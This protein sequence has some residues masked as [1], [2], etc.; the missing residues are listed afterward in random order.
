MYQKKYKLG[1]SDVDSSL[2][3]K[4]SSLFLMMQ[5]IAIEHAELLGIGKS[6]TLDNGLFWVITR[7]SVSVIK[8]PRYLE[9]ITIVTY[10]GD[11]K[12]FLFPRY[13][14]I[15]SESGE[16]LIRASSIWCVLNKSDHKISLD[17]FNGKKLPCEHLDNEEPLP[18]KVLPD[19]AK[20]V[21]E[22][23]LV[24]YSETD[25]NGHLNNT[26]YIEYILDLHPF[27][28][29]QKNRVVHITINYE[30]EILAGD[31]VTLSSNHKNPEYIN[32]SVGDKSI[33]EAE[34]KFET[35]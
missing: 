26:K 15:R 29:Y 31:V 10:P 3:L 13:F 11:D 2:E 17:P 6:N 23:R 5:D 20:E 28:F 22:K 16:V 25:L 9:T 33:F 12:K 8:N 7:Y 24:R 27:E 32:G 18:T 4:I 21:V 34:V 35:K 19:D 1:P 30:K 14:E